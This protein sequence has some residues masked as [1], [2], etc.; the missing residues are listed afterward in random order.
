MATTNEYFS[1]FHTFH[2]FTNVKAL[3]LSKQSPLYLLPL[4]QT[5]SLPYHPLFPALH[6]LCL[7]DTQM[8]A[9]CSVLV[10]FL[11]W[12]AEI[13]VPLP[14]IYLYGGASTISSQTAED[15]SR[16]T[17]LR[18]SPASLL[19]FSKASEQRVSDSIET[20]S[21]TGR[22]PHQECE[23]RV[24]MFSSFGNNVNNGGR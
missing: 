2:S 5:S 7:E 8:D 11:L 20:M 21:K 16:L 9:L 1:S 22:F 15:L 3:N 24:D 19:D 12:R 18:A 6:T 13:R 4:F 10:P 23:V 17:N 14:E